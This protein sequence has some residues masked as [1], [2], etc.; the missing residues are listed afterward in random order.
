MMFCFIANYEIFK[1]PSKSRVL[2]FL[3]EL[4][5]PKPEWVRRLTRVWGLKSIVALEVLSR[6]VVFTFHV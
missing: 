4:R 1:L 5:T 6:S 2:L 3:G